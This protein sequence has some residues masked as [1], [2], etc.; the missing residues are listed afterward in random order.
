MIKNDN[1]TQREVSRRTRRAKAL[2]G[3]LGAI[4]G[5]ALWYGLVNPASAGSGPPS[6]L[7]PGAVDAAGNID[8]SRIPERVK[9]A[10]GPDSYAWVDSAVLG[11]SPRS[12]DPTS[13]GPF[14]IY[15]NASGGQPIAW[16]YHSTGVVDIGTKPSQSRLNSPETTI[17]SSND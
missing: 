13:D 14:L 16:Y 10:T 11:V 4:A 6:L 1:R 7:G 8:R 5:C 12:V 17:I 15:K 2:V 9:V 3:C